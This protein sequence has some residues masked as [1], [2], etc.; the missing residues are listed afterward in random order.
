MSFADELRK[1]T[2]TDDMRAEAQ[3]REILSNCDRYVESFRYACR[4]AARSGKRSCTLELQS[5]YDDNICNFYTDDR[6]LAD[7]VCAYADET[8]K[9]DGFKRLDVSVKR[10]VSSRTIDRTM[11]KWLL[12]SSRQEKIVLY[13]LIISAKW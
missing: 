2:I 12:G 8:L 11:L 4:E 9:S 5:N 13:T 1:Q 10:F 6:S 7:E 3:R